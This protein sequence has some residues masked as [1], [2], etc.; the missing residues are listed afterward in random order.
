MITATDSFRSVRAG[1]VDL[2]VLAGSVDPD[3][4]GIAADLAVLHE[5]ASDVGLE[6]DFDLLAAVRT[7]DVELIAHF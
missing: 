6:I 4:P 5:R 7:D 2:A 1:D 3:A